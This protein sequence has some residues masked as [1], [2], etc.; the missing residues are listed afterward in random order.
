M[1][2]K[3]LHVI[4]VGIGI[5]AVAIIIWGVVLMSVRLIILEVS[6]IKRHSI[7]YERES[8]RHQ[9]GSYLLL[10]LEFLIAADIIR[11]VTHPTLQDMAV[12]AGIVI[13]R[14]LIS[15]FLDREIATFK[16]PDNK[17]SSES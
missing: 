17:N 15:F 7:Y 10:G 1:M 13:I 6:R 4:S 16:R 2:I 9:L 5:V 11:T 3:I 14:T 8:L 12:L